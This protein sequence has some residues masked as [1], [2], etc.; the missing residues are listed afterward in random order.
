[1]SE[2]NVYH[3]LGLGNKYKRFRKIM[4][5]SHKKMLKVKAASPE[6]FA[7]VTALLFRHDPVNINYEVNPDEYEPE[8][9]T[10]LPRLRRCSS[11]ADVRKVVHEEF[12]RWF[13]LGIAGPEE[14]YTEI[15]ADI[16]EL[17]RKFNP[18]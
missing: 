14:H 11:P 17:W 2:S 1:M 13:D 6:L 16:W 12:I 10:I 7:A 18:K 4:A 8:A 15:A 5:N 3:D 9:G